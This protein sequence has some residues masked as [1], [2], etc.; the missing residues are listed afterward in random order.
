[1]T[2]YGILPDADNRP[3]A[4][5]ENASCSVPQRC[6]S[7]RDLAQIACFESQP[8]SQALHHWLAAYFP[9]EWQ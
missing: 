8:L 6:A 9:V 5:R 2:T 1:M 4:S 7:W 3:R